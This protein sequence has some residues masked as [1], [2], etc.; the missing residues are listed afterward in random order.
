MELI[1]RAFPCIPAVGVPFNPVPHSAAQQFVNRLVESFADN[2]P[3]GNFEERGNGL[4]NLAGASEVLAE[5]A[6]DEGLDVE[7]IF[8]ENVAGR[9]FTEVTEDAISPVESAA[10]AKTDQS[11]I[12]L[13]FDY[14]QV[15]PFGAEHHRRYFGNLHWEPRIWV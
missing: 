7:W 4:G 10:F 6:G 8:A 14:G 2:V 5:H 11:V 13:D 12:G 1:R 3:A 9:G 15:T